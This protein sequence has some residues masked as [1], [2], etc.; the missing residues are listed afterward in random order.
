MELKLIL[1]SIL[2]SAQKPLSLAELRSCM[3]E[4]P[5]HVEEALPKELAAPKVSAMEE[6]L[7]LL[8]QDYDSLGRSFRL[9]CVAGSWQ[10]VSIPEVAPWVKALVG[11]RPRP[12]RLSQAALET[13]AIIAYRQP[14]TRAEG[15]Q[16]RGVAIDGVLK[17]LLERGL[18]EQAG[19]AEVLGRPMTFRTTE[20]FLEYFGLKDLEDLPAADELR[21]IPVETPPA[22]TSEDE[23]SP[24]D[25][26]LSLTATDDE[27]IPHQGE[28][29][30]AESSENMDDGA[31]EDTEEEEE[32]VDDDDDDDDDDGYWEEDDE[33]DA[34]EE[35]EDP[36]DALVEPE[37]SEEKA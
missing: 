3:K 35:E 18:V 32:F 2:F 12:P 19:R 20:L 36:S 27:P 1:E 8:Q 29:Q 15:E 10:F 11:H 28:A 23:E 33:G 25:A 14:L 24:A 9:A 30:G 4:A 37:S 22:L 26:E 16:I 6:A 5:E 13:L 31:Q 21:R 7:A 34:G 17:M